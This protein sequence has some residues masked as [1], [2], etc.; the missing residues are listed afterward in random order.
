MIQVENDD[1]YYYVDNGNKHVFFSYN[2]TTHQ[3]NYL[4][5]E[6]YLVIIIIFKKKGKKKKL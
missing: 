1:D 3:I 5:V 4:Q 2:K 6:N